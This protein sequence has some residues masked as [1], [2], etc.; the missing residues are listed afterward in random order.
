MDSI[1]FYVALLIA[2]VAMTVGIVIMS[3]IIIRDHR[4]LKQILTAPQVQTW[5]K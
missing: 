1:Y 5:G 3:I 4:E 2:I